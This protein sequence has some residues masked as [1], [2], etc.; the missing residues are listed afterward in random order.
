MA[1]LSTIFDVIMLAM[2]EKFQNCNF[3]SA[4]YN[5]I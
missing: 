1:E 5:N 2:T 3:R 4:M